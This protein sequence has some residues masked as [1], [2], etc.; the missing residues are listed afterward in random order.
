MRFWAD[1]DNAPH[2][3]VLRPIIQELARRGHEVEI[4]ARDHGQTIPLL[5]M[6]GLNH[7]IVGKHWGKNILKKYLSVLFR[8]ISLLFFA[9]G[10]RFDAVFC[11][12]TRAVF[13]PARILK[14]PL[15]V[16]VDYEY[17][18]VLRL[19]TKW[20][21][22]LL[23]PSVI[24]PEVFESRGFPR[25]IL[26]GYD[27]LKEDLYIHD[28][29][30][31]PSFLTDLGMDPLKVIVLMRPP[32][33]MAHYAVPES[34]RFFYDVMEY[35]C[36]RPEVQILLI[37]RT[38]DQGR[39]ITSYLQEKGFTNAF[40]P[41]RV[42]DGPRMMKCVDLII[43]GGGT[44]NREAAVLGVPVYSIYQGHIGAVDMNLMNTHRLKHV[45]T[46]EALR[47]IPLV[48]RGEAVEVRDREAG[49]RLCSSM[50]DAVI[51][52]VRIRNG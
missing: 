41:S 4:T 9:A 35:L 42:Y 20:P 6:Y 8:S 46:M 33:T 32:A 13:L 31:D 39:V 44:M 23:F 19:M 3:L 1:I 50:A 7:R 49:E 17:T 38:T 26:R 30:P 21:A 11:H 18:A 2:V 25:K 43:S 51:G 47:K 10:K 36:A 14:I 37:P 22:L 29:P 12:G 27:G 52:C 15:V 16:L 28:I 45:D 40:I 34:E 24:P 5:R 48:K